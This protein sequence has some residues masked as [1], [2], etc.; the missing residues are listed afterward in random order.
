MVIENCSFLIWSNQ[1]MLSIQNVIKNESGLVFALELD[2]CVLPGVV[3]RAHNL[4]K[5]VIDT[6]A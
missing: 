3:H 4:F 1:F 2:V 6:L 5:S